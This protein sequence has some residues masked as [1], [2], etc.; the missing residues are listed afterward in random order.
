MRSI[1]KLSTD[2]L[3]VGLELYLYNNDSVFANENSLQTKV[4]ATD[5]S[6]SFS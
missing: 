3:I 2:C 1:E 4:T 5:A 6:N